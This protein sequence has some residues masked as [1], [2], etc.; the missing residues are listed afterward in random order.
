MDGTKKL[1]DSLKQIVQELMIQNRKLKLQNQELQR[2]VKRFSLFSDINQNLNGKFE[3]QK[4]Y[5]TILEM[6]L[7]I[8]NNE[9]G[10]L[11]IIN[12]FKHQLVLKAFEGEVEPAVLKWLEGMPEEIE[13]I[14]LK[15]EI[16]EL[17]SEDPLLLKIQSFDPLI[18]SGLFFPLTFSREFIGLG[19][20]MH[21]HQEFMVHP[22]QYEE[23]MRFLTILAQQAYT[24]VELNRLNFERKNQQLYLKTIEALTGAID[25]KDMY[26]AGHSQRVAEISTTIAYELGLTQREIDIIHYGALLHDIGKI[27]IPESI[28]N[29][30]GRLTDEEFDI[31]KRHPVIGTNILRSIDFLEDALSI[32]RAHHERYDGKGYPDQLKGE[33]IPFMAR[34]V[35]VADAWDAMTS[36]RSYRK[37]LPLEVVIEELEKNAGTQFDPII[38]RTLQ[39]K[40][41][42]KLRII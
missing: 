2:K 42:A 1:P 17:V 6:A 13:R 19:F 21:R 12:P 25:A 7:R 41:F 38:V 35:C 4:F 11:F 37:A 15:G 26:T 28:L 30:K 34:I 36:D 33:D 14:I 40:S 16:R 27:G 9:V 8:S 18:R 32:V 3:H 10:G 20:V 22:A 5:E 39:R 29:K 24:F 23:D 31:I